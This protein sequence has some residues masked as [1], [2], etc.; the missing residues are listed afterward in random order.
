[1][2]YLYIIKQ[3]KAMTNAI[4]IEKLAK[5]EIPAEELTNDGIVAYQ[6]V[7]FTYTFYGQ[8]M[9]DV[10]DTKIMADGSQFVIDGNGFIKS[11]FQL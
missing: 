5:V 8:Q 11:G 7:K 2:A 1:M 3:H 6:L 9:E 4:Q 10:I